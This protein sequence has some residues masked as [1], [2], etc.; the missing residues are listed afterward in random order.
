MSN[1]EVKRTVLCLFFILQYV[2]QDILE[3]GGIVVLYVPET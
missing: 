1:T 3:P 2:Q